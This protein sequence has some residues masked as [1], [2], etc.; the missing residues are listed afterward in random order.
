MGSLSNG[1]HSNTENKR[2]PPDNLGNQQ[3]SAQWSHHCHQGY[4]V[5]SSSDCRG[6]G[7]CLGFLTP[8]CLPFTPSRRA[9]CFYKHS[10][11]SAGV[12]AAVYSYKLM[13]QTRP[14]SKTEAPSFFTFLTKT[15]AG[16]YHLKK[17][18]HLLAHIVYDYENFHCGS[19][20]RAPL[21][22]KP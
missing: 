3:S 14:G 18:L 22:T 12:V 5:S 7:L 21:D 11:H 16:K 1:T 2:M 19:A 4:P 17:N 10:T 13:Q 8:V 15:P 9:C 6:A 20:E